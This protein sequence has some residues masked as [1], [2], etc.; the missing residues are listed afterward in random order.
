MD[1]FIGANV[2]AEGGGE[3]EGVFNV[4]NSHIGHYTRHHHHAKGTHVR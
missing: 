1:A 2:S 4:E 3:G